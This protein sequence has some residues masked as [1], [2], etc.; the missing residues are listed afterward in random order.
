MLRPPSGRYRHRSHVLFVMCVIRYEPDVSLVCMKGWFAGRNLAVSQVTTKYVLWVDD[1]FI[2]SSSTK[3]EKLVDV[4]ERTTLDLVRNLTA[5]TRLNPSENQG[6]LGKPG[7]I[8]L[9]I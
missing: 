3:L 6:G 1:D 2:F 9:A 8:L 5:H 7:L 4:L